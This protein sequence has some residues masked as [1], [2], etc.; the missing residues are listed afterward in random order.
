MQAYYMTDEDTIVAISTA[1]GEGAIGIVRLSGPQALCIANALF[2]PSRKGRAL[3]SHRMRHGYIVA[4]PGSE[5]VDE[6][7]CCYMAAPNTYTRQDVV[8]IYCHG[9]VA[10]QRRVLA[11][12]IAQGARLARPGEFTYRAFMSGRIDLAQAEAALDVIRA[13]TEHA[14]RIAVEHLQGSLSRRVGILRERILALACHMEAWLDFPEEDIAPSS[15]AQIMSELGALKDELEALSRGYE[16]GRLYREG[17]RAAIV[18]KPNVGKSSLLNAL[19]DIERAIVTELPGTTRDVIEEYLDIE[20]L[21]IRIM[22][23]AGLR[24][25]HDLAEKEGVRRS[26][27][28]LEGADLA[29]AVFDISAPLSMEDREVLERIRGRNAVVVLNKCDLGE[30]AGE[31]LEHAEGMPT[32]RMSAKTAQG[33]DELRAAILSACLKGHGNVGDAVLVTNLR[34]KAALEASALSIARTLAALE[35]EPLEIAAFELRQAMDKLG[36]I[37]GEISTDEVLENIFSQFCIGK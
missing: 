15:Q 23:T 34:H 19:L 16:Q 10:P 31:L 35:A 13:K 18:G 36:E 29:L 11:L 5:R 12:C 30:H 9:G 25:A 33:L 32:V 28:A 14:E 37:V 3:S 8:E 1:T 27:A 7:L 20:G 26:L 4:P 2:A 6:V 24:E 17:V 21:P 22:D